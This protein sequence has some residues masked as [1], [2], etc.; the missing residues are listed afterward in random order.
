MLQMGI[1]SIIAKVIYKTMATY[2]P[3]SYANWNW[4][5]WELRSW[6]VHQMCTCVQG[7]RIR[8]GRKAIIDK[9]VTLGSNS[10]IGSYCEL[11]GNITIGDNVLMASDVVI[12]TVSHSFIDKNRLIIEQGDMEEKPVIIHDDVWIARRVMIMPGVTIHRGAV[13]AAGAVVTKDVPP[14]ALVGG[15][16]ARVIKY[17]N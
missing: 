10:G 15:V 16:P 12:Y 13:I 3:A 17:R 1:K 5:S 11:R 14:Y 7:G 6:C 4:L 9:R 2:L 8:C